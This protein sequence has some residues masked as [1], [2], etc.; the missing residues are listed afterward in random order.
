MKVIPTGKVEM[1]K[2]RL[3]L[4][5]ISLLGLCAFLFTLFY[6]EARREADS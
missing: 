6:Q 5:L 1:K 2:N 3:L 4:L